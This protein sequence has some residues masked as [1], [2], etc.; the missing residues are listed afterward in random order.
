MDNEP[1]NKI[2]HK[3]FVTE[4]N[5]IIQ[6]SDNSVVVTTQWQKEGD[7]FIKLSMY[8]DSYVPV[9]TLGSTTLTKS[10]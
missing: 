8:D 3:D 1:K 9:K 7:Y 5:E 4:Y 2:E 10:L 6:V